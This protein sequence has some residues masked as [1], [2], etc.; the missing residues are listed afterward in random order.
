MECSDSILADCLT[1][2]IALKQDNHRN[3]R[4][5]VQQGYPI[6]PIGINFKVGLGRANIPEFRLHEQD[7][8]TATPGKTQNLCSPEIQQDKGF[9]GNKMSGNPDN[10]T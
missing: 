10:H 9:S 3:A 2:F 8:T 4:V 5:L 7:A 6:I 1:L